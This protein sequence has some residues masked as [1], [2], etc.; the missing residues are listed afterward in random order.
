VDPE[1][2]IRI[3]V[4]A[5]SNV[6]LAVEDARG[7]KVRF[8]THEKMRPGEYPIPWDGKDAA[9]RSLRR[10]DYFLSL[11]VESFTDR[12]RFHTVD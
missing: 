8:L 2:V 5:Q 6:R 10:G 4:N 9:G 11:S 1:W 3:Q 12:V 7:R